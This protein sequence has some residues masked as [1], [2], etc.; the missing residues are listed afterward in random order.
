MKQEE[1]AISSCLFLFSFSLFFSFLKHLAS[2][3]SS[4]N[5]F[6]SQIPVSGITTVV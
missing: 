3:R 6:L 5:M 4:L 2:K 1:I